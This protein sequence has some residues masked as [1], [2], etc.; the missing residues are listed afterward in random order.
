ME[1]D[2]KI[3]VAGHSGLVGSALVGLLKEK[4]FNNILKKSH[5]ELDLIDQGQTSYFF[6]NEKPEYVFLAAAK[7]GG[8]FANNK[9]RAQFLY[10]NL[11]IQNNVIHSSHLNDVKKLIFLGS[12]CIYPK[13]SKQPISEK[14]LLKGV[15]EKTNE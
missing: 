10:E 6:D 5:G 8:I 4:G 11:M 1:K 9:Y 14:E 12:A 3:F 13:F 7:V 2:S 15:L